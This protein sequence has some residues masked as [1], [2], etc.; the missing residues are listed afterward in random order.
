PEV[1]KF[2]EDDSMLFEK[3][4][5]SEEADFIIREIS[6]D[7]TKKT[8]FDIEDNKAPGPDGFTS[9]FFKKS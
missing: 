6:N 1:D 9:R 8:L 5:S 2:S 4:V 3:K 7:E